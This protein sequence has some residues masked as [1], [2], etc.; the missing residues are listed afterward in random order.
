[1]TEAADNG[2]MLTEAHWQACGLECPALF[3]GVCKRDA[4][5]FCTLYKFDTAAAEL[6]YGWTLDMSQDED[7]GNSTDGP[8]WFAL[9]KDE[10]VILTE[11]SGGRVTAWRVPESDD[12]DA[13]W[14][15]IARDAYCD[16]QD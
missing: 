5:E 3:G 13:A 10:R 8:A 14:N 11:L 2:T 12:L 4:G 9:F 6:I 16:H 1:M 7:C 15:A